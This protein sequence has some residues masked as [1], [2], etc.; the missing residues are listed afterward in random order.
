[1][2]A[3]LAGDGALLKNAL[4]DVKPSYL[5]LA[6]PRGAR[7]LAEGAASAAMDFASSMAKNLGVELVEVPAIG[8][9]DAVAAVRR[10]VVHVKAV[11]KGTLEVHIAL[12]DNAP[13]WLNTVL[14]YSSSVIDAL[15]WEGI[16]L[17]AVKY[18]SIGVEEA[19]ELPR[20]PKYSELN[21]TEYFV[22]RLIAEGRHTAAEIH[23]ALNRQYGSISRQMV[24]AALARLKAKGLVE[25]TGGGSTFIYRLTDV[26]RLIVG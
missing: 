3:P 10:G 5:V 21:P 17:G 14:L 19:E 1:L 9:V 25:M 8:F 4:A 22:L 2:V 20:L 6:Y 11:A 15:T 7:A 12:F 26:G 23:E 24:N 13:N 16:G 18:Y